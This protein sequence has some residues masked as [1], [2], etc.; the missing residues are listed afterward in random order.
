MSLEA[1]CGKTPVLYLPLFAEQAHNARQ[2]TR[3]GIASLLNKY[4]MN[5]QVVLKELKKVCKIYFA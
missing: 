3:L 5:Q 2:M 4:T 1:I